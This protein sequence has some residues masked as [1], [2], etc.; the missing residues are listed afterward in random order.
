MITKAHSVL[1]DPLL[2][3]RYDNVG[4]DEAA[5]NIDPVT[6]FR[7][8]FGGDLFVPIIGE[9]SISKDFESAL[10]GQQI[11]NPQKEEAKQKRLETLSLNLIEKLSIL[12]DSKMDQQS[13]CNFKFLMENEVEILKKQPKGPEL[14][15][16]VGQTYYLR[17]K[18][19]SGGLQG[20]WH[21]FVEKGHVISD[22]VS[23]IKSV[24]QAQKSE[25]V[26]QDL[27]NK[28]ATDQE[29]ANLEQQMS[30]VAIDAIW[31]TAKLEIESVIRQVCNL[32]LDG[33]NAKKRAI[34][35]EI[36]GQI[37]IKI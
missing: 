18:Q 13:I 22:S 24:Y 27:K 9:I 26:L 28:G 33:P 32:C 30:G 14:L 21:S 19:Y 17:A 37:Y 4:D 25:K 1:S 23:L 20:F 10:N 11:P 34:A 35:L 6:I 16:A 31:K 5:M 8:L 7:E 3:Q 15:Q 2:R 12:T 29:Q 36:L